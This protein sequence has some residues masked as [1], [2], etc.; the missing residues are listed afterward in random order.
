MANSAVE[1]LSRL[2]AGRSRYSRV[3]AKMATVVLAIKASAS[4]WRGHSFSERIRA[5][6][7][8]LSGGS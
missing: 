6:Q 7:S 3:P 8:G 4:N 1:W 5:A 2:M